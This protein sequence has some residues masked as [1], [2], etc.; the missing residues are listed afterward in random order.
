VNRI[1]D[2]LTICP[3]KVNPLNADEDEITS[4][5]VTEKGCGWIK[6]AVSFAD[7]ICHDRRKLWR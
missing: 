3:T 6:V 4:G 1:G 7:D 2:T 5:V